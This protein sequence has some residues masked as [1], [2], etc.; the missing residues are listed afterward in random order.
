MGVKISIDDFG[1][2]FSSLSYLKRF[3]LDELKIDRSF[4]TDLPSAEGDAAIVAAIIAM[5]RSLNLKVVA[6]GVEDSK[7]LAV[8]R[9]F[10]CD[11]S[12]GYYFSKPRLAD[13]FVNFAKS[14]NYRQRSRQSG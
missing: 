8:L 5:A 12:Q 2:G 3:P 10:D 14:F 9:K 4:V 13:D 6:E 11:M 7:Q 1:T